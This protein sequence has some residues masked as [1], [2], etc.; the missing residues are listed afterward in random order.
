MKLSASAAQ[1]SI[2]SE[3]AYWT[4]TQTIVSPLFCI[5]HVINLSFCIMFNN[6]FLLLFCSSVRNMVFFVCVYSFHLTFHA[7]TIQCVTTCMKKK[8]LTFF[9][10]HML[11]HLSENISFFCK[12]IQ[13]KYNSCIVYCVVCNCHNYFI[14]TVNYLDWKSFM[15]FFAAFI[16]VWW[17]NNIGSKCFLWIHARVALYYCQ[18]EWDKVE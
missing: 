18:S 14:L 1:Y 7:Q 11:K 10:L 6:F 15:I 9:F 16:T 2:E 4:T 3:K 8:L 13:I 12:L 17:A 5:F